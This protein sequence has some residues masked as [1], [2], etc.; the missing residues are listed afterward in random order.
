MAAGVFIAVA[1]LH[2]P[3]LWVVLGAAP[4]SLAM[5]WKQDG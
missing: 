3:M 5:A 1:L 4:V 2:W